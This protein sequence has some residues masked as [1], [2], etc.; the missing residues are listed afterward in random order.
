M[1]NIRI[2]KQMSNEINHII[3]T[4]LIRIPLFVIQPTTK[5]KVKKKNNLLLRK[6]KR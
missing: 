2:K 6:N 1:N 5:I 4:N 3:T